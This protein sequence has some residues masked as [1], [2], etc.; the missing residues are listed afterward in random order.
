[1]ELLLDTHAL[2]WFQS[3]DPKLSRKALEQ[4]SNPGNT[5]F[6]SV[7]SLWEISIKLSIDKLVI[8]D[9]YQYFYDSLIAYDFK[10]I[11]IKNGH[12]VLLQTL[13]HHHGDP[14]DLLL[15]AQA[16]TE[17]LTI[18]SANRHLMLTR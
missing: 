11:D 7:A 12:L 9:G 4:I 14:F 3:S 15:I 17:D 18:I 8:T 6:I 1:M 5:C 13:P 10:V 16:I 2:L